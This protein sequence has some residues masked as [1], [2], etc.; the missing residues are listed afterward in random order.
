VKTKMFPLMNHKEVGLSDPK[1]N[2]KQL[3]AF[4]G[5]D[6][7]IMNL[8]FLLIPL[9]RAS[10][11]TE[12]RDCGIALFKKLFP[13]D[14][15]RIFKECVISELPRAEIAIDEVNGLYFSERIKLHTAFYL[16]EEGEKLLEDAKTEL[17]KFECVPSTTERV[18]FEVIIGKYAAPFLQ[19]STR[20]LVTNKDSMEFAVKAIHVVMQKELAGIGGEQ[21][22]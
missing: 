12:D 3:V 11:L 1:S 19:I 15:L 5:E 4:Q 13:E 20:E 14:D 21:E 6:A 16:T 18:N 22:W 7:Y 10:E 9:F 8:D 2:F 17:E